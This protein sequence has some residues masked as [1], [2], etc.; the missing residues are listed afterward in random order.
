MFT[1]NQ[2]NNK[3]ATFSPNKT[4]TIIKNKLV[5]YGW[6]NFQLLVVFDS[7][8]HSQNLFCK[9]NSKSKTIILQ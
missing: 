1:V 2:I 9:N 6:N 7:M 5:L 8:N 4:N 3:S